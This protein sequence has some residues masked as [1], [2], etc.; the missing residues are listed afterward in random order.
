MDL[1]VKRKDNDSFLAWATGRIVAPF[2][3]TNTVEV[4]TGFGGRV[5]GRGRGEEDQDKDD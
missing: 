4:D 1:R 5:E 3:L 2:N